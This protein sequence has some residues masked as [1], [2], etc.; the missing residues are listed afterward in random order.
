MARDEINAFLGAGTT[1]EGKLS[2]QGSVR[3]DGHFYGEIE[4]EGTLVVGRDALV[5]G[6]LR[7]GQLIVSGNLQGNVHVTTRS[8]FS[9]QA[10]FSGTLETPVLLVEEGAEVRGRINSDEDMEE[11]EKAEDEQGVSEGNEHRE[12]LRI[13]ST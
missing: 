6:R 1:Y 8:V 3:I 7:V 12:V 11:S 5:Q 4:S 2:F 9:K 13:A 10:R